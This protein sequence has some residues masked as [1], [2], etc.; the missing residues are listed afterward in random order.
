VVFDA[1]T[2]QNCAARQN[3]NGGISGGNASTVSGCT[4]V[5]NLSNGITVG[6]GATV[7]HSTV[8]GSFH[9]ILAG[10]NCVVEACSSTLNSS[11]GIFVANACRVKDCTVAQNGGS[12]IR[13]TVYCFITGNLV[14]GNG[15]GLTNSAG[16]YVTGDDNQ[17]MDNNVTACGRGIKTDTVYN[18]VVKNKAT[19][20][21][22]NYDLVPGSIGVNSITNDPTFAQPWV[23]FS[24]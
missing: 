7:V 21:P 10:T 20:N 3:S 15:V 5:S 4:V 17:I 12:G 6:N 18:L 8:S 19:V 2:I 22:L 13:G 11:N 9:G 16:I 24:F 14:N 1:G 23:N